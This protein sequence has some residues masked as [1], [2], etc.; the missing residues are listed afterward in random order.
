[1]HNIVEYAKTNSLEK[2]FVKS[3]HTVREKFGFTDFF[4]IRNEKHF[5][6]KIDTIHYAPE[7]F[8]MG[9]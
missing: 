8:K 9:R 2:Y 7:F 3:I 4:C 6:K 5:V 1:M